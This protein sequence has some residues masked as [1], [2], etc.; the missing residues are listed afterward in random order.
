MVSKGTIAALTVMG[1]LVMDQVWADE[2]ALY[3]DRIPADAVFVRAFGDPAHPQVAFGG[4]DV[5]VDAANSGAYTPVSASALSGI[6]AG[7]YYSVVVQ[8]D[9]SSVIHEPE[10]GVASKV[11]LVLVNASTRPVRL[12]A[13]D[14]NAEVIGQVAS[15]AA[16]LRGVNPVQAVLAVQAVDTGEVL[17]SFEVRLRR[18]QDVSFVVLKDRTRLVENSFAPVA[19][20]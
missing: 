14:H 3:A 19:Q 13:P 6:A 20:P 9:T 7:G 18:G 12:M 15:G 11:H 1:C 8:D 5:A 16:G 2:E 10:R 17:G 4:R